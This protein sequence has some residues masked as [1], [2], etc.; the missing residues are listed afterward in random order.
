MTRAKAATTRPSEAII[1]LVG[2][3]GLLSACDYAPKS[4][5]AALRQELSGIKAKLSE[6]EVQLRT[7]EST[8]R[9]MREEFSS[10]SFDPAANEGF[11]R[12]DTS[13]GS[14]AVSLQEVGPYADGVKLRFHVGNLTAATINGATFKVKWG[15]RMP[16][17]TT[18]AFSTRYEEWEKALREKEITVTKDFKPGTWNNVTI[19][20]PAT[21]PNEFGHIELSIQTSRISLYVDR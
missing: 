18:E 21:K 20:L 16:E 13:V 12:L 17:V 1:V 9:L 10:A 8:A 19:T 7:Q 14:L 6:I 15:P 2:L 5:I 11:S 3:L 4:D